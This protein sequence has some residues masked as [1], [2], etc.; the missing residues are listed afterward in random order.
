M[1]PTV[2]VEVKKV[3]VEID[4]ETK[5]FLNE[6]SIDE[7]ISVGM[8]GD[9]SKFEVVEEKSIENKSVKVDEIKSINGFNLK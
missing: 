9:I 2:S 5:E 8:I 4:V 7:E 6:C 1:K 3:V